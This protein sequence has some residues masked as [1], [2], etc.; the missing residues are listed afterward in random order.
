MD[1]A[2]IVGVRSVSVS[3]A[4]TERERKKEE[5]NKKRRACN[6]CKSLLISFFS[7]L[8]GVEC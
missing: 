8:L 2:T 5:E 7:S 3:V 1:L 4:E 6:I